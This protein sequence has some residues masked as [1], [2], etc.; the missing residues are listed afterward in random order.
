MLS[1][2][3]HVTLRLTFFDIFAVKRTNLGPKFGILGIPCGYPPPPT[4]GRL[5]VRDI[6]QRTKIQ[7]MWLLWY[8]RQERTSVAFVDNQQNNVCRSHDPAPIISSDIIV[9]PATSSNSSG[10]RRSSPVGGATNGSD[11]LHTMQ[12]ARRQMLYSSATVVRLYAIGVYYRH[13]LPS[14]TTQYSGRVTT[15]TV[16]TDCYLAVHSIQVCHKH[17]LLAT[18]RRTLLSDYV[19]ADFLTQFTRQMQLWKHNNV[20]NCYLFKH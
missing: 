14:Y 2:N 18:E 20:T 6:C 1:S 12:T 7:S 4:K 16:P 19:S 10:L 13:C 15:A 3:W 8:I 11:R 9:Q 5:P 17:A